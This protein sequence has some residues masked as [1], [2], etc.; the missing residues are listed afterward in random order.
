MSR[1]AIRRFTIFKPLEI[2]TP[3]VYTNLHSK[4]ATYYQQATKSNFKESIL[5]Q[6]LAD[7]KENKIKSNYLKTVF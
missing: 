2:K 6:T 5:I 4:P 7:F 3:P 1:F